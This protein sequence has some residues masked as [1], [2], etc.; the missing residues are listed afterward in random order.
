MLSNSSR[1]RQDDSGFTLIE[2]LVAMSLAL[3]VSF[4]AFAILQ[5]TTE[6][7]ARQTARVH[8]AQGGRTQL[9]RIMEHLHSAC[10]A[11]LVTP[12]LSQSSGTV[13]RFISEASEGP[14]V[15]R[16]TLHKLTFSPPSAGKEGTLT[17]QSW[18][19]TEASQPPNYVFNEAETPKTTL[20]MKGISQSEV[21]TEGKTESIPI[22]RY[23]RYYREG[24]PNAIFGELNPTPIS[25]ELTESEARL[26]AR[27][28]MAFTLSPEAGDGPG[29]SV[30]MAKGRPITF[31][32]SAILR[33]APSSSSSSVSNLPCE[34]QI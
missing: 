26:V 2:L 18:R 30:A 16:A 8:V 32:D 3:V 15:T 11:A 12:V 6:D 33:V 21:T 20:L 27:V 13:L 9:E 24:D 34:N 23:Y 19:S 7:I 28:T 10:V 29:L 14:V 17:E 22:F 1:L 31:E 25:G 4:G 5:F